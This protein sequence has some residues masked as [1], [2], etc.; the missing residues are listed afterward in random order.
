MRFPRALMY[1][2][3][4]MACGFGSSD[5]V[6]PKQPLV[7]MKELEGVGAESR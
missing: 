6:L 3:A 1:H 5:I 2:L 4:F 7:E